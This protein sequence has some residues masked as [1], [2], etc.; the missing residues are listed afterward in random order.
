MIVG[1]T[2]IILKQISKLNWRSPDGNTTNKIGYVFV[3]TEYRSKMRKIRN[4]RGHNTDSDGF[5]TIVKIHNRI[6]KYYR[7][8]REDG[9][10]MYDTDKLKDPETIRKYTNTLKLQ[11]E[12]DEE[13]TA[14]KQ[15][16]LGM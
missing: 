8:Q 9:L 6:N 13:K 11:E 16:K 15:W 1:N 4:Y 5:L 2:T 3:Y 7:Y 10:N 14:N 12:C